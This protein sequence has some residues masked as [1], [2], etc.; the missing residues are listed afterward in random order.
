MIE[1][2]VEQ[3]EVSAADP[4]NSV[5]NNLSDKI[6]SAIEIIA[7]NLG[8]ATEKVYGLLIKQSYVDGICGI[9]IFLLFSV[10]FVFS[11]K[12]IIKHPEVWEDDYQWDSICLYVTISIIIAIISGTAIIIQLF[13]L[14]DYISAIINPEWHA[15]QKII[16]QIKVLK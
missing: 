1:K 15:I 9:F 16:N 13:E 10:L 4:I 7:K 3:S 5:I 12:Y 8:I 6:S 14:K 11:M 2:I